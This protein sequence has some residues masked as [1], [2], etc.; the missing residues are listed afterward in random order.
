MNRSLRREFVDEFFSRHVAV[1]SKG[2]TVLDLGGHRPPRRGRF[3]IDRYGLSV[4][5]A[6]ISVSRRPD[7]QTDAS[8]LPFLTES[9]DAIICSELLE[10]V[11]EPLPVL[12]EVHRTLR[13]HGVLLMSVPFLFHIHADPHDYGR[14]TDQ[15]WKE[16]LD[17]IGFRDVVI[18]KQGLFWSVIVDMMRGWLCECRRTGRL[19][20]ALSDRVATMVIRRAK[21]WA[22]EREQL[23][24]VASEQYVSRYTTGFGIRAVKP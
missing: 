12:R 13:P 20:S 16:N 10:H 19:H 7:V 14:Y 21:K 23:I 8:R 15:Y 24:P 1:I 22:L 2:S 9:F 4:R 11:P 6:N 17:R 5:S 3:D 18:E